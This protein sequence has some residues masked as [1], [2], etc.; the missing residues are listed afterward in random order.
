MQEKRVVNTVIRL[1]CLGYGILVVMY[2]GSKNLLS[3]RHRLA[4]FFE[5]LRGRTAVD[6][7]AVARKAA[8]QKMGKMI[9]MRTQALA[10]HICTN[11]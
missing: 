4:Y 2:S 5:R 8:M 7:T 6:S 10:Q 11:C 1:L 3:L 9:D